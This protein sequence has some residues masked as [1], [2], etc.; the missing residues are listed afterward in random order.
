MADQFFTV[1]EAA[2]KLGVSPRTVQRY[3]KQGRLNHQWVEGVRHK[4]LRIV[5]PISLDKLPGAKR[6]SGLSASDYVTRKDFDEMMTKLEREI[7]KKDIRIDELK[8]DIIQLK[9][10]LS[11]ASIGS[12]LVSSQQIDD[13]RL[14]KTAESLVYEF[15]KVRPAEKKL[16]L[17]LVKTI[18]EHNDFLLNLGYKGDEELK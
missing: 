3:C 11:T 15:E 13:S 2:A 5:P 6:R 10:K 1:T 8:Q 12:G 18:K 7:L 17:K 9:S 16:I 4:E 14:K